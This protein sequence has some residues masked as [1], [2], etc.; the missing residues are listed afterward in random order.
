V[1]GEEV[2]ARV[3]PRPGRLP[4]RKL[5]I[6]FGQSAE[7]GLVIDQGAV[8]ALTD[9]GR[10][11]FPAGI[12]EVKGQFGEG[13]AVEVWGPGRELVAKGLVRI[14]AAELRPL[15]GRRT[16]EVARAGWAGEVIH[17]DDLVVLR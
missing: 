11:L 14:P 13:A 4:A 12:T 8:A 15:L 1:A 17:R 7:G 9:A 2:G 10:S 16:S 5:W 6:A 3:E